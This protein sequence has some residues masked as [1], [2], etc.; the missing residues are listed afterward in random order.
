MATSTGRGTDMAHPNEQVV[1]DGF[2]AFAS[3]DVDTLR[4][5]I[6]AD[7]VWHV[8]GRNPLSGSHKGVDEILAFFGMTMERSG[9]TFAID[10]HDV[11][12]NDEH[13]FAAYSVTGQREGRALR[14]QAVLV[15]HVKD[16]QVTEAWSVAGDQY[17]TDEFWS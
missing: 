9:G 6:A 12:G 7:A 10:L 3:N 8:G 4:R 1:R 16:G 17:L 13:V 11:V 14:D 15:F 5:L 2:A